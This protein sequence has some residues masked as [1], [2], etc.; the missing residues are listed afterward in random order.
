MLI[1]FSISN[2]KSYRYK[3]DISFVASKI[4]QYEESNI[5]LID[6]TLSTK[7]RILNSLLFVGAN[8]VGKTNMLKAINEIKPKTSFFR[9]LG[10]YKVGTTV[11]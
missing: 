10:S 5:S 9:Y 1:N 4:K 6:S 8:S 3:N 7:N 11:D 2:Y